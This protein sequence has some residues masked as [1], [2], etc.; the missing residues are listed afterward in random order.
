[1]LA[2]ARKT[3]VDMKQ[4]RSEDGIDFRSQL[5]EGYIKMSCFK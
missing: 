1:M 5:K 3:F 4:D 2:F